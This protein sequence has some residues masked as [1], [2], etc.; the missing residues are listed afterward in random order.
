MK[1]IPLSGIRGMGKFAIVDDEDFEIVSKYRWHL[2]TDNYVINRNHFN[3]KKKTIRM[4]RLV[5][6][7]KDGQ[8]LDHINGD[9]LDNRKCN[10]RFSTQHENS[11]N[12]RHP[13]GKSGLIGVWWCKK[14]NIWTANIQLDGKCIYIGAYKVK[15]EAAYVRDQFAIQLHGEFARTNYL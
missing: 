4:H 7:A 1:Q 15:E 8:Q 5:I 3:K 11:L 2:G 13:L 14:D 6:N 9:R 10:L 12:S